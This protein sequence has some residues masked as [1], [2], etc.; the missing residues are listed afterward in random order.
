MQ[1]KQRLKKIEDQ[2]S[3]NSSDSEFCG[4][5]DTEEYR[6]GMKEF[7]DAIET[8]EEPV[9]NHDYDPNLKTGRCDFCKKRLSLGQTKFLESA[10]KQHDAKNGQGSFDK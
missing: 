4:C 7:F 5:E 3:A 2:L 6:R 1:L 9:W 8:E 10:Q